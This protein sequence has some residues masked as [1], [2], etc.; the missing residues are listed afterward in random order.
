MKDLGSTT[1]INVNGG[2]CQEKRL[3]P[4]DILAVATHHYEIQYSPE[5]LGAT[6]PPPAEKDLPDVIFGKSLLER[7]G[8]SK[9][10]IRSADFGKKRYDV[11]NDQK[12][13]IRDPNK[14]V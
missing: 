7:A 8:L 14:P 9:Q 11:M 5:E 1:G 3:D 2:R 6:G 4:G 13:Q 10:Q 12:G